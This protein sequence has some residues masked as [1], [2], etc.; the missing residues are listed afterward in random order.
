MDVNDVIRKIIRYA[1]TFIIINPPLSSI[2]SWLKSKIVLSTALYWRAE[3][4]LL[5]DDPWSSAITACM[6]SIQK[7]NSR[8][9]CERFAYANIF[10]EIMKRPLGGL[11]L[12]YVLYGAK[13]FSPCT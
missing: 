12:S 10:Y 7:F 4:S 1:N 2:S 11:K 8:Y 5:I 13:L 3:L 9:K 6:S